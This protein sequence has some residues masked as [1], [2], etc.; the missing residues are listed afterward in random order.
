MNES[1]NIS[2]P[3]TPESFNYKNL[4][5]ISDLYGLSGLRYIS[6]PATGIITENAILEDENGKLYFVKLYNSEEIDKYASTYHVAELAANNP[7]IPVSLP[8]RTT[9]GSFTTTINGKSL[10]L[11]D[12]IAHDETTYADEEAELRLAS[13]MAKNLGLIHTVP[14]SLEDKL[15]KPIE[16]WQPNQTERRIQV[17]TDIITI[18]QAKTELDDFDTLALEVARMKLGLLSRLKYSQDEDNKPGLCHGDFHTHN[19]L[20]NER[21]D[22][23]AILDW[24][25]AG[26]SNTY[27][28]MLNSFI[29]LVIRHRFDTF[30]TDRQEIAKVFIES[31]VGATGEKID[32]QKLEQAYQTI[33]GERIGTTWPMNQH[34]LQRNTKQDSRLKNLS[35]KAVG[36]S[37]HY[38]EIW[39]FICT[40][41]NT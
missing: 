8:I 9:V 6:T 41:V 24:D 34:Y 14:V 11:F 27:V 13:S 1:E 7:S 18:I 21:M 12:Y 25:N 19:T 17:L 10:A 3:N 2:K 37:K 29:M 20:H 15:L 26:L 4:T 38:D 40:A 35:E 32:M 30:Q 16:R 22:V 31:Y 28:D 23:V 5:D 33:M 36:L 39:S